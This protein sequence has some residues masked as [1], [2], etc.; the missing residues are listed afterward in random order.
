MAGLSPSHE[1]DG[2]P[3]GCVLSQLEFQPVNHLP[4]QSYIC[5]LGG[6]L[7]IL[8][9]DELASLPNTDELTSQPNTNGSS[10]VMG[11]GQRLLNLVGK[12]VHYMCNILLCVS[13][14]MT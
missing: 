5:L 11:V 12:Y 7:A 9:L 13:C 3:S 8:D 10:L 14:Y 6:L 4:T 2:P 1:L